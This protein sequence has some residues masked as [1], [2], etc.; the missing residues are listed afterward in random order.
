MANK[1]SNN[2]FVPYKNYKRKAKSSASGKISE[3]TGIKKSTVSKGLTQVGKLSTG[4]KIAVCLCFVIG[5]VAG[6][7]G[8]RVIQKDDTFMLKNGTSCTLNVND[9]Y[10]YQ[11]IEENVVC[12]SYGRNVISSVYVDSST[13]DLTKEGVYTITYKCSDIKYQNITLTKTINVVSVED[14]YSGEEI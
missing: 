12:I 3:A 14:S 4:G 7:I 2:N 6:Y 10:D 11:N 13:L 5:V 9:A 8:I 1:K